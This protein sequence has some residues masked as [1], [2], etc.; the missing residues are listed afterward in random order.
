MNVGNNLIMDPPRVP[1][2]LFANATGLITFALVSYNYPISLPTIFNPP[3][4]MNTLGISGLK[5]DNTT[6]PALSEVRWNNLVTLY[7][8]ENGLTGSVDS[9]FFFLP[10]LFTF[11]LQN[12]PLLNFKLPANFEDSKI[13]Q[14][15]VQSTNCSGTVPSTILDNGLSYLDITKTKLG[16]ALPSVFFCLPT[17]TVVKFD[18]ASFSNPTQQCTPNIT[19]VTPSPIQTNNTITIQG[20][21]L[22]SVFPYF[23]VRMSNSM[24]DSFNLNCNLLKSG[25]MIECTNPLIQGQGTITVQVLNDANPT[26][27]TTTPYTYQ[28]PQIT[29]IT[30]AP[31]LGGWITVQGHDLMDNIGLK[32]KGAVQFTIYGQTCINIKVLVPYEQFTC[33]IGGGITS[34]VPVILMV[35]DVFSQAENNAK[36]FYKAP[37]VLSSIA[38]RPDVESQLT[39]TGSDFW[40]DKSLAKVTIG[41]SIN[42]P[43]THVNH[44]IIVCTLPA[45]PFSTGRKSINVNVNGQDSQPNSLFE[46][47]DRQVCPEFCSNNGVCDVAIGFC[48]CD[49]KF[50]PSC[51][52]T[53]KP[54]G[55]ASSL[56][57]PILII[58]SPLDARTQLNATL[59]SV[60]ENGAETFFP[61]SWVHSYD[62][63]TSTHLYSWTSGAK[64]VIVSIRP[65][66]LNGVDTIGGAQLTYPAGSQT[67]AVQYQIDGRNPNQAVQFKFQV[68]TS[69]E[70]CVV[71]DSNMAFPS[72]DS[73]AS[74]EDDESIS[75]KTSLRWMT[76]TTY[77]T[78][79]FS[80][81]PVAATVN[82]ISG[83]VSTSVF[84]ETGSSK[85]FLV[86]I[87]PSQSDSGVL[88]T[89]FQYDFAVFEALESRSP[90]TSCVKKVNN[91]WKIAVGVVLGI[92]GACLLGVG[93]FFLVRQQRKL[94]QTSRLLDKKLKELNGGL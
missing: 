51:T 82:N 20:Q 43:V 17:I 8:G 66:T 14:L 27:S 29:S 83:S 32:R 25:V 86:D 55:F 6:F 13:N 67:Y 78:Q 28:S 63:K 77:N 71:A 24:G 33:Y 21:D 93:I 56:S 37:R 49:T 64:Q 22:G 75:A 89:S 16:G 18:K 41:G 88:S 40:M 76:M 3:I 62:N 60:I 26:P 91:A 74:S 94:D 57:Q 19:M 59:V 44:S 11:I 53:P 73:I 45:T 9:G 23:Q 90:T 52:D 2:N 39:I 85:I 35:K 5:P 61:T 84:S 12:N 46:F 47:A 30:P 68:S 31:T 48:V 54:T 65:N 87:V 36:F 80:R 42:C 7:L 70:E 50:G 34:N 4:L 15:F 69:P 38:P 1:D 72:S 92:A 81:F 10:N 58:P 79:W